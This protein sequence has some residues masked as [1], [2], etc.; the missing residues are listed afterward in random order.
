MKAIIIRNYGD[1]SQFEEAEVPVP[2]LKSQ[3]VLVEFTQ[4]R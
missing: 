3:D 2:L 4:H 1:A